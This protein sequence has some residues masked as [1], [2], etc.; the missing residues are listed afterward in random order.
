M[1]VLWKAIIPKKLT[2]RQIRS[3]LEKEL[4]KQAGLLQKEFEKTTATWD[5]QVTFNQRTNLAS[6]AVTAEVWTDDEIY[7]YVNDGTRPHEIRPRNAKVLVFQ[8]GYSAK[9]SPGKVASRGGGASGPLVFSKGVNH[10]GTKARNFDD[11]IQKKRKLPF[12]FGMTKAITVG[13]I[14]AFLGI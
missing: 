6:G 10:P 7:G 9:T 4:D 3:E 11:A 5:H 12:W 14:K 2:I 1:V 8:S 13:T